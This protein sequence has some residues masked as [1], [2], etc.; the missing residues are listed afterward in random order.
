MHIIVGEDADFEEGAAKVED[1]NVSLDFGAHQAKGHQSR[2][3][4][5]NA[6]DLVKARKFARQLHLVLLL[7]IEVGWGRDQHV[8]QPHFVM[9]FLSEA[10]KF[11][12]DVLCN[13][14]WCRKIFLTVD[15]R[16]KSAFEDVFQFPKG[17][18]R[19]VGP[20]A[21]EFATLDDHV[22]VLSLVGPRYL[23][24]ALDSEQRFDIKDYAARIFFRLQSCL[25]AHSNFIFLFKANDRGHTSKFLRTIRHS[26]YIDVNDYAGV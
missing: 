20:K 3:G 10:L 8:L 22:R 9:L 12:Y 17:F 23:V 14:L 16:S 2:N 6:V 18:R 7:G 25:L 26:V 15:L 11:V 5:L 4:R 19:E 24:Y 21:H 1:E 13:N